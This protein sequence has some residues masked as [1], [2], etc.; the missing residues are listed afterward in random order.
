MFVLVGII[1]K[2]T[3]NTQMQGNNEEF[4]KRLSMSLTKIATC[5]ILLALLLVV[6]ILVAKSW[7]MFL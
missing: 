1:K 3:C 7:V 4:T 2:A 5:V 6:S